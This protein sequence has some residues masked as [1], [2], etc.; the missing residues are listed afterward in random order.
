MNDGPT[1][2]VDDRRRRPQQTVFGVRIRQRAKELGLKGSEVARRA[3]ITAKRYNNYVN[4]TREP[5]LASL[6]AIS[7][8]LE[9]TLDA[10][11]DP[12][13]A[14]AQHG[15]EL[16]EAIL[17][18]RAACMSLSL[19]DARFIAKLATSLCVS[20]AKDSTH[21][22][23]VITEL[24]RAHEW[25]I[26]SLVSKFQPDRFNTETFDTDEGGVT[27]LIEMIFEPDRDTTQLTAIIRNHIRDTHG[28]PGRL[29][30]VRAAPRYDDRLTIHCEWNLG[31]R[32]G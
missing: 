32:G 1:P 30:A 31:R 10:L 27:L 9:T 13:W 22:D 21:P 8:V 15:T 6:R 16:N 28:A 29:I 25:L 19:E 5:D 14:G 3:G 2:A 12:D 7:T 17:R 24:R 20:R 26:P 11:I 23:P 18:I 4:G